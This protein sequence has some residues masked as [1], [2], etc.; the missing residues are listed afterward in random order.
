MS[1]CELPPLLCTACEAETVTRLTVKN[2]YA[3]WRCPTC[4]HGWVHPVPEE[5]TLER[6]YNSAEAAAVQ[7]D[8]PENSIRKHTRRLFRWIHQAIRPPGRLLEVGCG[9][10]VHLEVAQRLGWETV[11]LDRSSVARQLCFSR[12]IPAADSLEE[13]CQRYGRAAFDLITLWEVI[14]HIA[15]LSPFLSAV[16]TLLKPRGVLA[17][18]TPNFQSIIARNNYADWYELRPPLHLHYFTPASLTRL[19]GRYG[20]HILNQL[21]YVSWHPSVDRIVTSLGS[22]LRLPESALFLSQVA[23]YKL[24]K[25][26][27]DRT[28][29]ANLRGLGL[30]TLA[31]TTSWPSVPTFRKYFPA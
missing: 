30:L 29:Q 26:Y 18:S 27:F 9:R 24:A 13:I 14:E 19:L 12:G 17:L 20:F 3:I 28:L 25:P 23:C 8:F 31:A 16:R 15:D 6:F 7:Y 1:S 4:G 11:G 21:T 2:A 5:E 22:C 10:G